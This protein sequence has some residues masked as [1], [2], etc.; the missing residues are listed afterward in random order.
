MLECGDAFL[1]GDDEDRDLHLW[2]VV[3]SPSQGEVVTV[4]VT[5]RR[6][7]SETLVILQPGD[8]PF[9]RH[10]SV[11][12]YSFARV[13][14]V[15]DIEDALASG[16]FVK[17]EPTSCELLKRVQAG[18]VDSDFT[19]NGVRHFYRDVSGSE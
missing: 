8:H 6:L 17:K 10:E 13:R 14:S 1:A 7:R 15:D 4:S 5:F 3:T 2:I 16:V 19:P 11:V 18:L 9:V 12:A